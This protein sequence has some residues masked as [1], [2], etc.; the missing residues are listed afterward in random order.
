MD[1]F[2]T[3]LPTGLPQDA[4]DLHELCRGIVTLADP[5]GR[6]DIVHPAARVACDAT[7]LAGAIRN[8]VDNAAR[9]AAARIEIRLSTDPA[10]G[11][12]L[13]SVADDGPGVA[14]G[15]DPIARARS[16]ET[17]ADGRGYGLGAIIRL[18][19]SRGGE[20]R[21]APS[22]L[23]GGATF[24]I[25]LPGRILDDGGCAAPVRAVR[26]GRASG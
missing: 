12:L 13:V 24:E 15:A 6:L 17:R 8:L 1:R 9:Y 25:V 19:A 23:G 16:G 20:L 22:R 7:V 11:R 26:T 14:A 18:L 3:D 2:R 4:L 10:T 5:S 21:T